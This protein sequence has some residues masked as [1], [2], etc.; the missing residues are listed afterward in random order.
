MVEAKEEERNYCLEG[1][2]PSIKTSGNS[3]SGDLSF[4]SPCQQFSSTLLSKD[5]IQCCPSLFFKTSLK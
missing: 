3:S 1:G 5:L 2:S 4:Y